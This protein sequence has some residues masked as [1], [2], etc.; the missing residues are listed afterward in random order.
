[1]SHGYR[2]P[3]T[4]VRATYCGSI[5]PIEKIIHCPSSWMICI[6]SWPWK[7][8]QHFLEQCLPQSSRRLR[9]RTKVD[10]GW[11]PGK[12]SHGVTCLDSE[13]LD[14]FLPSHQKV[15]VLESTSIVFYAR[16]K[17]FRKLQIPSAHRSHEWTTRGKNSES[18]RVCNNIIALR[19]LGWST[20]LTRRLPSRVET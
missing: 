20:E 12:P 18:S 5:L 7:F 2:A 10:I 1:M 16:A 9:H 11:S 6:S 8:I 3:S 4:G 14:C 15:S 17:P 19:S 13:V